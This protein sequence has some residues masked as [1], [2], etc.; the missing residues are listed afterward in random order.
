MSR[1][2][3]GLYGNEGIVP[4]RLLM[5]QSER[6]LLEQLQAFPTLLLLGPE[7]G[8]DHQ[9]AMELLCLAGALLA[10]GAILLRPLRNSLVFLCLWVIYFSLCQVGW[11]TFTWW[12]TGAHLMCPHH[13][14]SKTT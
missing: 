1:A 8:L 6:P 10:L 9:Q 12:D 11:F 4:V 7:L 13:V 5:A 14:T 3:A 2:A